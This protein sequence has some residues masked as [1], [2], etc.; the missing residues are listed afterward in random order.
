MKI[1][2]FTSMLLSAVALL[3]F[4]LNV[5]AKEMEESAVYE[6]SERKNSCLPNLGSLSESL[7][8]RMDSN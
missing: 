5:E 6:I 3:S 4:G 7:F 8:I 1:R 2:R